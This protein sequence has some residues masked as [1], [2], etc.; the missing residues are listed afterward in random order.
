MSQAAGPVALGVVTRS[1]SATVIAVSGSV[2]RPSVVG[3]HQ[4]VLVSQDLPSQPYHA[5]AGED[6]ET[7]R[8]LIG[9]VEAEAESSAVAAFR[10]IG[11]EHE[12]LGVAVLVKPQSK[13]P[14][15]ATILRSHTAIHTAEGVLYRNVVLEA[16]QVCGW[17]AHA[18][19]AEALPPAQEWLARA[20]RELGPPWRRQEKDAARAAASLL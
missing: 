5:A 18:I 1:G 11:R 19:E 20:G 17:T 13:R 9:R 2:R 15:L 16:A 10:E 4:L 7:A 14:D 8:N 6:L 3:R 12:I